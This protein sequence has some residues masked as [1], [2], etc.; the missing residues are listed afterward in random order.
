VEAGRSIT[1]ER[2]DDYW[3]RDVPVMRGRNNIGTIRFE[4]YRDRT[5]SLEAFKAGALDFRSE[6]T[7]K[8]WATQYDFPAIRS[9]QV[10]KEELKDNTPTGMQ[11]FAFNIRRSKFQDRRVRAALTYAFDFEW[12]NQN[13]FY[14]QYTRTQSYFSNSELASSG[15]PSDAELAMLEPLRGQ[16]PDEI[17]TEE[18]KAPS[19]DGRGGLRANLRTAA[20]M[21]REA[22]WEIK[23]GKLVDPRSGEP[24]EIEILLAQE[25]FERVMAPFVRNLERLGVK[26]TI[27]LVD[28]SQYTNRVRDFDFDMIVGSWGQSLSPGNEQRGFWGSA[29]ADRPGSRNLVGIKDPA[30][31]ALIDK[32]IF[33]K[34]RD[35]L[36]TACRAL[37]RVLLWNHFVIPNWHIDKYRI[38]YW[39]RFGRPDIKPK[40]ALGFPDTWWVDAVKDAALTRNAGTK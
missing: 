16:I 8:F 37:D 4:Y 40:Y 17:F 2:V 28:S 27:R 31:D 1:F 18:Y 10:I 35:D 14:G 20:K 25:A 33:A 5:V 36:I 38:A 23:D 32:V 9:G 12:S 21:L 11:S 15:L 7:A 13:L 24:M 3:G 6:N 22:G 19:T 26:A 30:I 39:N 34:D 29:A